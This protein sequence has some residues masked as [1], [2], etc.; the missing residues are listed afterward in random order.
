MT[1]VICPPNLAIDR[2]LAADRMRPGDTTRCRALRTQPGGK[3]ANVARATRA[4]GGEALLTGFARGPGPGGRAGGRRLREPALLI[5]GSAGS[6]G[7]RS[8]RE[9]LH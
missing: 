7:G 6:S 1:L 4:L 8:G 9:H 2:M 3:G 5:R